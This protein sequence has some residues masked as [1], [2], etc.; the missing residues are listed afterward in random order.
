MTWIAAAVA[1]AVAVAVP[2]IFFLTAFQYE[3]RWIQRTADDLARTTSEFVYA[4]PDLWQFTEHRLD[5]ILGLRSGD[6]QRR[7]MIDLEGEI[8]ATSQ[9]DLDEKLP[10]STYAF[11]VKGVAEVFNGS[12]VV[13][14][15]HVVS[16]LTPILLTTFL[17]ALFGIVLAFAV[18]VILRTL[19]LRALDTALRRLKEAHIAM[20]A[21]VDELEVTK[22]RLERQGA[23]LEQLAA[24]L[25]GARDQS[26]AA[27]L[28]KSEFLAAMSHELRT[29][30][31][32]IIGFSEIINRETLGPVGS[33]KYRDYANDINS[34][35][36][37]LLELINDILD[38]SKIESGNDELREENI[39]VSELIDA[40]RSLV[41]GRAERDR[42]E[43]EFVM[44]ER[45]PMLRAD[46]R[47]MKQI[48][49]NLLSN[50]IKFT[51]PGGRVTFGSRRHADG[52]HEFRIG[53]NGIGIARQDIPK[54]LAPF[55]QIEGALARKH[56]GTGLGLPLTKSL[57]EMHG[58]SMHLQS[59][60]GV[61]T[62]VTVRFPVARVVVEN[63][64]DRIAT[65]M[66]AS[67]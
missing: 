28:A 40:V 48:L 21:R 53:D 46:T 64:K 24:E 56:Q 29:P 13:G 55:Q 44:T 18:F 36:H 25:A 66:A 35:G 51:G 42:V 6:E 60:I 3:S 32:A 39:E 59:E 16:S 12:I 19:P 52:G 54:A 15:I 43:L 26:E 50:A 61:G 7:H 37:H 31:N 33:V 17:V 23:E 10:P 67:S 27:N 62:T 58:G 49:V 1:T 63:S 4:H 57:I 30:L 11:S 45:L 41:A 20:R 5:E 65:G 14:S 47:K 8:I 2:A 22:D 38:L 34:A 9:P